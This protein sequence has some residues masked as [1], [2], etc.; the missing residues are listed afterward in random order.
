M[1]YSAMFLIKL[2]EVISLERIKD[3]PVTCKR[4]SLN[5]KLVQQNAKRPH[6]LKS[7]KIPFWFCIIFSVSHFTTSIHKP[8]QQDF[9]AHLFS[10]PIFASSSLFSFLS[11]FFHFLKSPQFYPPIP[12]LGRTNIWH[13][14]FMFHLRVD[15]CTYSKN[16][17]TD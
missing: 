1:P 15:K 2:S 8:V 6:M 7:A 9:V 17:K 11:C 13:R 16:I 14:V 3:M 12:R 4:M 5:Y 10:L